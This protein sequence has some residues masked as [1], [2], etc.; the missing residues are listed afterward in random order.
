MTTTSDHLLAG[1]L[2][3]HD[4]YGDGRVLPRL[5]KMAEAAEYV[6]FYERGQATDLA[7]R[8]ARVSV[9]RDRLTVIDTP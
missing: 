9:C 5:S 7:P 1:S 4:V 2:V 3:H 6:A 8:G